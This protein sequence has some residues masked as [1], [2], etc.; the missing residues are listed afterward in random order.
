M[1]PAGSSIV[2]GAVHRTAVAACVVLGLVGLAATVP[3]LLGQHATTT[4]VARRTFTYSDGGNAIY[5]QFQTGAATAP[6]TYLFAYGGSGCVS[7]RPYLPEYFTGL[8]GGVTVVA[9]NKR[10]VA[11][12]SPTGACSK[13]F[14]LD[15]H[16]RQWVADYMEFITARL[17]QA[18][19]RPRKVVLL[20]V[21]E[22]A[23]VAVKVA[24]SLDD[25]TDLAIIGD[26]GWP[27]RRSL[28][29]LAGQTMVDE[30]WQAIVSDADSLEK[31]WLG[32]PYRYWFEVMDIDPTPDY[33]GLSMPIFMGFGERDESVPLASALALQESLKQ[34]GKS[35][36]TLR[37]Y[38]GADHTL[39]AGQTNHRRAFFEELSR[40]L[41]L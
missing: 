14:A 13:A 38:E 10:H 20:G 22:G 34:A 31:T 21:S 18:Q 29:V 6:D 26:G 37:V 41:G 17:Q 11:D 5:H 4:P 3:S 40:R 36:L 24:R 23:Y 8:G 33:L 19:P 7:W 35:N 39:M 16:P 1:L 27:M 25:V 2:S 28:T 30:G 32:H 15:N 9:L 12:S